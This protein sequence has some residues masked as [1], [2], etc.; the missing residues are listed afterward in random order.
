MVEGVQSSGGKPESAGLHQ[1]QAHSDTYL[2][3]VSL[4]RAHVLGV[5]GVDKSLSKAQLLLEA[6]CKVPEDK[7]EAESRSRVRSHADPVGL[8]MFRQAASPVWPRPAPWDR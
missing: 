7:V 4:A 5:D 1:L 3:S 8:R 6:A 2:A